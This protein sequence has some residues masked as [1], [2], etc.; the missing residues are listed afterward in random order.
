[1]SMIGEYFRLTSAEL[2]RAIAD[3]DW[4]LDYIEEAQDAE[5]ESEPAPAEARH[6]STYKAWHLLG[7]LLERCGFPVNVVHG[8]EL[9]GQAGDWGYGPPHYLP[10]ERVQLGAEALGRLTYD[11][12]LEGVD[13]QELMAAEIYPLGWEDRASVEW[14]REWFAGLTEYF[15]AAAV[16]GHALIVWLD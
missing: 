10:A 16:E 14:V 15:T 4:V 7:F 13:P 8:E 3:P 1:M 9:L 6:F 11:Q 5:E 12:L 2:E